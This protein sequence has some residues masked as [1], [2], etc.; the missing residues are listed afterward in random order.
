MLLV[1]TRAHPRPLRETMLHIDIPTPA[2]FQSLAAVKRDVCVSLYVPTEPFRVRGHQNRLALEN[3]AAEA[4]QQL[5]EAAVEKRRIAAI[6]EQLRRLVRPDED[7]AGEHKIRKLQS[8]KRDPVKEFWKYQGNGLAVLTTPQTIHIYR[9]P[10]RPPPLAEVAD[11][12]HLMPLLRVLVSPQEIYVLALSEKNVRLVRAF[13]NLPPIRV[14][15]LG[16][17]HD[18]EQVARRASVRERNEKGR[19]R[20]SEGIKVLLQKFVRRVDQALE[21]VLAGRST[22]L[23]LAADEPLAS[24]FRSISTYPGLMAEMIPGNPNQKSDAQLENAALPLLDQR[25]RSELEA[26]VARYD[27]LKP[28]R[29][30]TDI[31]YSAH[32]A[33]AGAIEQLLVD[34]DATVPGLVSDTDGSVTYAASDN[35]EAYNVVDEIARRAVSTGA[36]VLSARREELP[37]GAPVVAI[38]R[39]QFG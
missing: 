12:F 10:Y 5:K 27:E 29:A 28:R 35:A 25:Y 20:G 6:D 3:L 1:E 33:T 14:H 2:E 11:R 39:Y 21:R 8:K 32:A 26:V 4:M 13:A 22:P 24:M 30:T 37:Q 16:L 31:S 7:H 9:M 34:L 18:A 17:P 36:H 23:V 38:L 15:V 19:L